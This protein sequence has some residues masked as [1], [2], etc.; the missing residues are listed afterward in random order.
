LTRISKYRA[1]KTEYN[2]EI[3]DSAAEAKLASDIELLVKAGDVKRVWRQVAF[4]LRGQN[5]AVVGTHKVDFV[6]NFKDGHR[7]IW[8]YKGYAVRDW[9]IRRK[10]LEDNYPDVKYVVFGRKRR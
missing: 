4:P 2:G 7:E 5:G 10:L 1:R 8:E 9:P 3:Y 6:L